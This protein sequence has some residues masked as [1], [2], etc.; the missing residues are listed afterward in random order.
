MR[1]LHM[2]NHLSPLECLWQ[3]VTSPTLF[4]GVAIVLIVIAVG[5]AASGTALPAESQTQ[6]PGR[7]LFTLSALLSAVASVEKRRSLTRQPTDLLVLNTCVC[8]MQLFVGL[9]L[10]PPLLL[11]A[12]GQPVRE[13]LLSLARGLR[14]CM[15]GFQ[16]TI[17]TQAND[18]YGVRLGTRHAAQLGNAFPPGC[19]RMRLCQPAHVHLP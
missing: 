19:P 7:M 10:A 15:S 2:I 3:T 4:Q 9:F 8:A 6:Q 1:V 18:A 13:T 17:C 11:L 16:P 12:Q 5:V 14:C